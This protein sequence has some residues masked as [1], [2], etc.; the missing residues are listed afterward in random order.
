M[1]CTVFW[2]LF[3][4]NIIILRFVPVKCSCSSS[5][6]T[7]TYYS[8]G[9]AI[10]LSHHKEQHYHR[11]SCSCFPVQVSSMYHSQKGVA[12]SALQDNKRLFPS[13]FVVV[14]LLA[15]N[16]KSCSWSMSLEYL[17]SS[18]FKIFAN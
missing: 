2:S 8:I 4:F 3:S 14:L 6:F 17:V 10:A 9:E 11:L 13:M 5:I 12:R 16:Y 7:V 15:V 18:D 1:L